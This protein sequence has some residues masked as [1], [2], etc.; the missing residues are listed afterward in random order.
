MRVDDGAE[1]IGHG[2]AGDQVGRRPGRHRQNHHIARPHRQ[3]G[4]GNIQRHG[5]ARPQRKTTQP[6]AQ[7]H[8]AVTLF[9][10][11]HR[12]IDKGRRQRGMGDARAIMAAA[13]GQRLAQQRA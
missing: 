2:Q 10:I 1:I 7:P 8:R 3:G 11:F 12:R 4:V 5:F 9:Q 13:S 6:G